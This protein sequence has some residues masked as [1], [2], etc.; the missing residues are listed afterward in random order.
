[1]P[2]PP[3]NADQIYLQNQARVDHCHNLR[4]LIRGSERKWK[5]GDIAAVLSFGLT[6]VS[7]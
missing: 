1:M 3:P 6:V 2:K 5:K 7:E 4:K